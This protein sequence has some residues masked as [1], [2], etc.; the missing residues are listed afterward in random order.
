MEL[1]HA[2]ALVTGGSDGYGRGIAKALKNAGAEV[3]I[4]GRNAEKLAKTAAEL[5]VH[6]IQADVTSG[7][8]WDRV[9][10]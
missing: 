9:M 7:S 8:D 4:T 5:G 3:W 6:A 1:N 10:S 2:K